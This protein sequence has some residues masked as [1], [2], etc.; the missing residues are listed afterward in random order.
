[1]TGRVRRRVPE[2]R[3]WPVLPAAVMVTGFFLLPLDHLGPHRPVLSWSLFAVT[4]VLIA[5]LLLRQVT[6]VVVARPGSRPALVIPLLMCLSVLVFAAAYY[7]LAKQPGEFAG[8]VTRLDALYFTLVT[9]ATLGFGDITPRGQAARLVTMLQI[10]YNFVFLTA[11]ATA[12]AQHVRGR[13]GER[14][15][16]RPDRGAAGG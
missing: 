13:V 8:L 6:D 7:S 10:L 14:R 5:L 12:L 15:G 3:V 1:M 16:R 2:G 11:A 9:L 4:L